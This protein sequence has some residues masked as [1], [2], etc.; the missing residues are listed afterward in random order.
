MKT[1]L[2]PIKPWYREPW[3]WLLMSGPAIVVV[4]G[5]ITTVLAVRTHDGLVVDDYYK[6][7]LAVNRDLSRDLAAKTAG[8]SATAT[9]D[10]ANRR[11]T[12]S[13]VNAPVSLTNMTLTLSR[14]S[15]AGHDQ[16]VALQR[17][18]RR[19]DEITFVGALQP[20]EP[21]KWYITL[22]DPSHAWRLM[23]AVVIQDATPL[24]FAMG[25]AE[26]RA[27]ATP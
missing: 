15:V 3:P 12:V 2:T 20:L 6:Q 16:L 13:V 11:V 27:A 7:G 19:D 25:H 8:L 23:T 26:A 5:I 4:A 17:T 10:V 22:D 14:A 18:N 21:G 24:S 9:I 1:L